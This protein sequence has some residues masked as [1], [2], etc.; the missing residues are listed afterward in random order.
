MTWWILSFFVYALLARF[1]MRLPTVVWRAL[2]AAPFVITFI[3][4]ISSFL[5]RQWPEHRDGLCDFFACIVMGIGLCVSTYAG[6]YFSKDDAKRFFPLLFFFTGSMLGILWVDNIFVFFTFWEATAVCSFL[7]IAFHYEDSDTRK[8]ARQALIV[9]AAGGLALL[10]ALLILNQMTGST[11][12]EEIIR[13]QD[14]RIENSSLLISLIVF[15][16]I[17]KS[18][19]F[20]FHFWLPNAMKAPTPASCFLHSATMVKLGVF[21]L[22]RFSPLFQETTLWIVL[23]VTIGGITSLGALFISL[24]K[25]DLK[26]MFAWTTVSA[27]G[28]IFILLGIPHEYSWKS[29]VSY[30]F[31]HSCYKASLFLCVGNIDK[32]IGTRSLYSIN[33]LTQRMPLTSLAMILSLGSMIGL[34]FTLGFLGKE[35][36]LTSALQLKGENTVLLVVL[37]CTGALSI[38]VA[39]RLLKLIFKKDARPNRS[40]REARFS[41]WAP[42]LALAMA[43]WISNFFLSDINEYFLKP[44]VSSILLKR[45]DLELQA[46]TGFNMGLVLSIC[47]F[48]LGGVLSYFLIRRLSHIEIWLRFDQQRKEKNEILP[49]LASWFTGVFQ[50]GKLSNYIF[51]LLLPIGIW[52]F[53]MALMQ[54]SLPVLKAPH[55]S[56]G[57][58]LLAVTLLLAGLLPLLKSS[59]PLLQIMG[60]GLVGYGVGLLFI[61]ADAPDLAM[62]QMSVE[63]VSLLV[64]ILCLKPLQGKT[65]RLPEAYQLVRIVFTVLSFFSMLWLIPILENGKVPSLISPYFVE[66]A[67]TLGKG[68]N[69]VNVILVDFR[70]LDTMG[71]ITVLSIV[72]LG[73]SFLFQRHRKKENPFSPSPIIEVATKFFMLIFSVLSL[74]LLLRGH[75]NPGGGFVGGLILAIAL[76][77]HA[78]VFGEQSTNRFLRGPSHNWIFAGLGLCFF[79]GLLPVLTKFLPPFTSLWLPGPI[80]LGLPVL[81]DIGVYCVIVGVMTTVSFALNGRTLR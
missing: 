1:I 5:N 41:M 54:E 55:I 63:T 48:L 19:Q 62:T 53:W 12:L 16:A 70:A 30:I 61:L 21:L 67:P 50:N 81:F 58:E 37:V 65:L 3:E 8:S 59:R 36:L 51:W 39:Y 42:A 23:L 7:L 40:L 2:F 24:L 74:Y 44:I 34:P 33:N 35:Y 26:Q 20:P 75:N 10:T 57:P 29:F 27:L 71:E 17:T 15:A 77:F 14:K 46:W 22:A 69:V 64:L 52:T 4:A 49:V 13:S 76:I 56:S 31:A 25:T 45:T 18:A 6:A 32:Q 80:T 78:L 60:L 79:S 72:A 38:V 11:S 28:S 43:G 47:S 73:T 9:N 68:T 66:N